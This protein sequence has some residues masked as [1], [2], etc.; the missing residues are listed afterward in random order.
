MYV[1]DHC[2]VSPHH[3]DVPPISLFLLILVFRQVHPPSEVH[4]CA[5]KDVHLSLLP[6][7]LV[8]LPVLV[9]F[10]LMRFVL[11]NFTTTALTAVRIDQPCQL[12]VLSLGYFDRR[13]E[14]APIDNVC[15]R[16]GGD[17]AP[18]A[19]VVDGRPKR[20]GEGL[21]ALAVSGTAVAADIGPARAVSVLCPPMA[22]LL[23]SPSL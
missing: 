6:E 17:A 20:V 11:V 13:V 18:V 10:T 14:D 21:A 7:R 19:K 1:F 8:V 9:Q 23:S 3:F 15:A 16:R 12:L 4:R 22:F 2:F 5:V